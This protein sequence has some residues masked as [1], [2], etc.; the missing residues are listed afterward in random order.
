MHFS[1]SQWQQ[2]DAIASDQFFDCLRSQLGAEFSYLPTDEFDGIFQR[3]RAGYGAFGL[4][5]EATI[6]ALFRLSFFAHEP[7]T[8]SADFHQLLRDYFWRGYPADEVL[9]S[10]EAKADRDVELA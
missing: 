7:L 5:H 9:L 4:A 1:A 10:L 3:C 6:V 8:D 2:F